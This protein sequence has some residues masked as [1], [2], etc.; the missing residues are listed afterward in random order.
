MSIALVLPHDTLKLGVDPEKVAR[1]WMNQRVGEVWK[2][3]IS[4]FVGKDEDVRPRDLR[5]MPGRLR[6]HGSR[7]IRYATRPQRECCD[8]C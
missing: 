7:G 5:I 2:E 6:D 3:T 8:S 1:I 4:R